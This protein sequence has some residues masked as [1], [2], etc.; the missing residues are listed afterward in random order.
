MKLG[1]PRVKRDLPEARHTRVYICGP[2]AAGKSTFARLLVE[3]I[4]GFNADTSWNDD[5][6]YDVMFRRELDPDARDLIRENTQAMR[7]RGLFTQSTRRLFRANQL[8][9]V[10]SLAQRPPGIEEREMIPRGEHLIEIYDRHPLETMVYTGMLTQFLTVL[11]SGNV[12]KMLQ[13]GNDRSWHTEDVLE[14]ER[15]EEEKMLNYWS[16]PSYNDDPEQSGNLATEQ[17]EMTFFYSRIVKTC[18]SHITRSHLPFESRTVPASDIYIFLDPS[19]NFLRRNLERRR[20]KDPEGVSKQWTLETHLR[21]LSD[22]M[23]TE[24]FRRSLSARY[25]EFAVKLAMNTRV[26]V[27]RVQFD[28]PDIGEE[29]AKTFFAP[30]VAQTA[31]AI[32]LSDSRNSE[33]WNIFYDDLFQFMRWGPNAEKPSRQL[34]RRPYCYD[35]QWSLEPVTGKP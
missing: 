35:Q 5:M 24:L 29:E 9:I 7:T 16:D 12:R 6:F 26:Q 17:E 23:N 21:P 2:S 1:I 8:A 31:K 25:R 4:E 14:R 33:R 22:A 15:E 18:R 34:F 32:R 10:D 13:R 3:E 19:D 30:L 20:E 11:D 27:L 28:P